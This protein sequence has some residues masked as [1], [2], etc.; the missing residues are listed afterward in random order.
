MKPSLSRLLS[1]KKMSKKVDEKEYEDEL[2]A[3][4]VA[5][6]RIQQ[7]VWHQKKRVI[8]LFE[9]FDAAGKG[10]LIKRMVELLDPRGFRVH[11]IGPPKPEDVEKHWLYRFWVRLPDP[12]TIVFFDRS[13]YGRVLVERVEK[14]IPKERW[15]EGYR[16]INQFEDL[17]VA[18][19]VDVI[20]F[21][22]AI[23]KSEQLKRFQDRLNDPVKSWK[24]TTED[25]KARKKWD[26]YVEAVDDLL[27]ETDAKKRHWHLIA[28]NDKQHARLEAL[29]LVRANLG[30]YEAWM[31]KNVQKKKAQSLAAS[32]KELGLGKH[33]LE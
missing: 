31:E 9:G 18:D 30:S 7:A 8:I 26:E 15:K 13:W 29:R 6:L 20:K 2:K 1:N 33:S 12:G 27:K 23:D 24:L 5:M 16:E 28:G 21:F 10:G 22:L 3:L 19:G 25:V 17:L 14:L 32:L 4:Q 11:P